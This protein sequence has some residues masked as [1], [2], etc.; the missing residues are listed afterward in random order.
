VLVGRIP[1]YGEMDDLD[2]ILAKIVSYEMEPPQQARWRKKVLLPM[3]PGDKWTPAY[4]LGEEIVD[5]F[6]WHDG[7]LVPKGGWGY[8][9]VYDDY[10]YFC[11]P[12]E[13]TQ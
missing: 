8:H 3:K 9:R 5:G 13:P 10:N 7:I 11:S 1:Y 2:H 12:P 6:I 4:T